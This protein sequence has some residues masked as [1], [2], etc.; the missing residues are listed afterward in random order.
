MPIVS[1]PSN[2][3]GS[4]YTQTPF[5]ISFGSTFSQYTKTIQFT[6]SSPGVLVAT[7]GNR[8]ASSF[9]YTGT[10]NVGTLVVDAISTNPRVV[11][12]YAG[13]G[14]GGFLDGSA[15]VAKFNYPFGSIADASGNLYV[16]DTFNQMIRKIDP[17]GNVTRIAGTGTSN[18][19]DGPALSAQ[20][21]GT[22]DL[23]IDSS[24]TLYLGDRRAVRMLSN[25]NLVTL[26]GVNQAGYVEGQG[27]NVRF[28]STYGITVDPSRNIYV[29]DT[30]NNAIRQV[31]LNGNVFTL[32]RGTGST[33]GAVGSAVFS[34]TSYPFPLGLVTGSN[35]SL[36]VS[37][38]SQI[39]STTNIPLNAVPL[40]VV[41]DSS[42]NWV[43]GVSSGSAQSCLF[44]T[45]DATFPAWTRSTIPS[46]NVLNEVYSVATDNNGTFIAGGFA[47]G[48]APFQSVL[49]SSN[50]GTTWVALPGADDYL[51]IASTVDYGA[52]RWMVGGV[53]GT[54]SVRLMYAPSSNLN[55]WTPVTLSGITAVN[56]VVTDK[57]SNWILFGSGA[58]PFQ[59]S[60]NNG[61]TWSALTGLA[62]IFTNA[63]NA[64]L[65]YSNGVWIATR[66]GIIARSTNVTTWTNT[67]QTVLTQLIGN[68]VYDSSRSLWFVRGADP[69]NYVNYV[70]AASSNNGTSWSFYSTL[71]DVA[72]S[73]PKLLYINTTVAIS[74]A[75]YTPSV[76]TTN[77]PFA[78][79]SD[80]SGVVYFSDNNNKIRK[81]ENGVVST[82][83]GTG[84]A[85]EQ[86]G[87]VNSA[88]FAGVVDIE[89]G[90]DRSMYVLQQGTDPNY[91]VIVRQISNGIVS[92]FAGNG[93]Y[94]FNNGA[95][96]TEASFGNCQKLA[97][98]GSNVYICESAAAKIGVI[99]PPVASARP[100]GT[101]PAGYTIVD[102]TSIPITVG[103]RIDSSTNDGDVLNLYKY[104]PFSYGYQLFPEVP[105]GD[106]LSYARSS[107]ELLQFLSNTT[108]RSIA[109]SSVAGPT[110]SF[111]NAL[112]LIIDDVSGSIIQQTISNTVYI[113]PG[114]FFPPAEN[115]V[116]T[117]YKNEP[118]DAQRFQATI[119][120]SNPQSFPALPVGL[121]FSRVSSNAFD[122][123]GTPLAQQLASNYRIISTG[124]TNSAQVVSVPVNIRV[125]SERLLLNPSQPI[126][127][128]SI[129]QDVSISPTTVTAR[130]PPYPTSASNVRYTWTP[131]LPDGLV[132]TD[133]SGNV[134]SSGYI[135][136]DA[137]S[138]LVLRGTPTL[139]AIQ[140]TPSPYTVT[141]TGTRIS[142][143]VISNSN[144]FTFAFQEVVTFDAYNL[145]TLYVG[146][147][148]QSSTQSNSFSAQ[149]KFSTT[150]VPITN[151]FSP[152]LRA[153]LSLTF[154]YAAQRAYL[155]GTPTSASTDVFT[156]R[157]VN[158]N[159]STADIS[160]SIAVS[161]DQVT[162]SVPTA[163]L[164]YNFIVSR[165][166]SSA[167]TGYYPY[168]IQF[169]ASTLSGCNVTMTAT[170]LS[171]TGISLSN[172]SNGVF[173][174]EGTPY[175]V[176]PPDQV[177]TVTAS[178]S[179]TNAS[180]T[181]TARYEIKPDVVSAFPAPRG[182]D[183]ANPDPTQ[184]FT[185]YE[186]VAITPIQVSATALS[187]R[188]II[189]YTLT[190]S[191]SGI[192][193]TPSALVSGTPREYVAD[194]INIAASTGFSPLSV[195][196]Y[197][198]QIIPDAVLLYTD[199]TSYSV[200]VGSN[201]SIPIRSVTYSGASVSSFTVTTLSNYG[202][203]IDAS[204]LLSGVL[205]GSIPP[206]TSF[207][208]QGYAGTHPGT[209]TGT[210]T[211]TAITFSSPFTGGPTVLTP[212]QTSYVLY[213]YMPIP[214]IVFT[215]TGTGTVRFLMNQADLPLG[216]T[217]NAA[218]QKITGSPMRVGITEVRVYAQDDTGTR[219]FT[220]SFNV[221]IPRIIRQQDGAGS[222][223]SLLRQYVEVN[224]AQNARDSRVYPTQ[225][226]LLGEFMSPEA[227]DVSSSVVCKK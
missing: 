133:A 159:L 65:A 206:S 202:L 59:Y 207:T 130:C 198:V 23:D 111:S 9:G 145:Q 33:D 94:A 70:Y 43:A 151:I 173:Q 193:M 164:C 129:A 84:A 28:E 171:G 211:P 132:F 8:Y 208:V 223:T 215:G 116:Y 197:Y 177:I 194:Q 18:L 78:I 152:D 39:V 56:N 195:I 220:L 32:V 135:A 189:Q 148:V 221:L 98:F 35:V 199:Q 63:S 200:S 64:Y 175:T 176:T 53:A 106:T 144:T 11:L 108:T 214:P 110:T 48:I 213:Q 156:I 172:V 7:S 30:L 219:V 167:K 44:S 216:L 113:N 22:F 69:A 54:G 138:T 74:N 49:A 58:T 13:S 82:F 90:N 57:N 186:N 4:L 125:A 150:T 61:T 168:P 121:S 174:L 218:T 222:F 146:A 68:P 104:E 210:L 20:L 55:S 124:L 102:T 105:A 41:R 12:D 224:A 2:F 188:P 52:N 154:N 6:D 85:G 139:A 46:S 80:P 136:N 142:T 1:D 137:S 192:N 21:M 10:G 71:N 107:S 158:A 166:L 17:S 118:I 157:A 126:T 165:P 162:F 60:T 96:L 45:T 87:P 83:A 227:P 75:T 112:S 114:R 143:P 183:V 5:D 31:D 26:A 25:G 141:L 15:S 204:G 91:S 86:D 99:V 34:V 101:V 203:S 73:Y 109:F 191:P 27:S 24:G 119:P 93:T 89:F 147:Q 127:Y 103:S 92:R 120:L 178:S 205:T 14:I 100:G 180:N 19:V 201:V 140:S 97:V 187:G 226:R 67:G 72:L 225:E 185:F 163:D 47:A 36:V 115:S 181:A 160:A 153:D 217:W 209:L 134:R 76:A 66:D 161:N 117:F 77:G 169:R 179:A 196:E 88:T 3:S 16:A 131:A 29:A 212:I 50:G 79:H 122:L 81:I 123:V 155:T 190:A 40:D 62:S 51:S 42:G 149:T 128:S 95:A 182:G 170:G 37:N 184:L 38:A